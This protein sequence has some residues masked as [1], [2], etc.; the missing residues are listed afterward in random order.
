[1]SAQR[2]TLNRLFAG[3]VFIVALYIIWRS[4]SGA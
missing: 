1:L 3:L 2:S 4:A